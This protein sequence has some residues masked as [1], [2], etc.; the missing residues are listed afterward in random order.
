MNSALEG[1]KVL[2]LG[3]G[4]MPAS[5]TGM[6]LADNG[7]RVT[8]VEPS[9]GDR[10]RQMFPTGFLL[11]NRGKESLV[12]DLRT[13]DGLAEVARWVESAD[14]L[15]E[16]FAP[17]RLERWGLSLEALRERNPALITCSITGFGP[18]ASYSHLKCYEGVVAAKCGFYNRGDF[19]FREGPIFA[20]PSLASSGA[21]QMAFA[22]ILAALFVREDSGYGQHIDA[23]MFAG[24]TPLD[25]FTT[26]HFQ[27]ASRAN[28]SR[29]AA[30][31]AASPGGLFAASRYSLY[32][33]TKDNQWVVVAVQQT[34]NA[35][36]LMSAIGL[37][38]TYDDPRFVDAPIFKSAEDAQAW[39]TLLW[40]AFRERTWSELE[41]VLFANPD[42]PFERAVPGELGLEHPQML[43][44]GH[45]VSVIDPLVGSV[46]QVGPVATMEQSPSRI[47]R[48]APALGVHAEV[49]KSS[50][51]QHSG[52]QRAGAPLAGV[53]IVE[54]G[55]FFAMPFGVS[56][57]ASL[58]ARVIKLEDAN[59]DP[60]RRAFGGYAGCAKVME[61]KDSFS[62]DLKSSEG[63]AIVHKIIESADV[64]VLGFRSG[65]AERV[66]LDYETLSTINPR[67]VY[68]HSSGYGPDGPYANRP[69]YAQT[70]SA[71]VGAF[72]RN[73]PYWMD[74]EVIG[75]FG[76]PELEAIVAPRVRGPA[77][78][79]G[80]AALAVCSSI[81]LGLTH[82]KRTGVG[83]RLWT[84]MIVGN[85]Y[86]YSDDF[87]AYEGKA[88]LAQ[89]DPELY[90]LGATYRLYE[91]SEGWIF[92]AAPLEAEWEALAQSLGLQ[93]C[94]A[95]L[96]FSDAKSRHAN[97]ASLSDVIGAVVL[98]KKA[99]EWESILTQAGVGCAEVFPGTFSAFCS[100]DSEALSAGLV[101][102]VEHPVLGGLIRHG[103]TVRFSETPAR[104]ETSCLHADS[105]VKILVEQ[106]LGVDE[107]NDL[108]ERGVVFGFDETTG[109]G[110][111]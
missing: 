103:A 38:R 55:F 73:S 102:K 37:E 104:I 6:L 100:T 46:R 28:A 26:T 78:G 48:S 68:V 8:K 89:P 50:G 22:A 36:A 42:L 43:H 96:R 32:L 58:G 60:I 70:A 57:A 56:L 82:Q 88:P 12:A 47:E 97:D 90:G 52:V 27:L 99:T 67:L 69:M 13:P 49:S 30:Q 101:V 71:T 108:L 93:E 40:E 16:G 110:A 33:L 72:Q 7:A 53:T 25:Y 24:L 106:G 29:S 74:P 11:W 41:P 107:I 64:F 109:A 76:V 17:Q 10:V 63:R 35:K 98:T 81:L 34:Q 77:D 92:L 1:L 9:Q 66:G 61:G 15:I 44:N 21:A 83:Q 19:G 111:H 18:L 14:V 65:V 75:D 45:V 91:A 51:T 94:L 5:V 87:I 2:E 31:A 86:A 95:D 20:A 105:T 4:S 85:A 62:V 3:A 54:F 39:E 80:N 84:T 59:G 79:D 23:S